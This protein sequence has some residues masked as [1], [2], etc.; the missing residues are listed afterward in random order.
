MLKN[1]RPPNSNIWCSD[2]KTF[3]VASPR[4][5]KLQ[6]DCMYSPAATKKK[7]VER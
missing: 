5:H 3:T 4:N 6:T 2:E 1:I 7:D